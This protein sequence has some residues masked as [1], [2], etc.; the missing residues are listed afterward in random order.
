[1]LTCPASQRQP[2]CQGLL[3]EEWLLVPLLAQLVSVQLLF[4]RR[5][6]R[7][8][9]TYC[10]RNSRTHPHR[11]PK[12]HRRDKT[13]HPHPGI[14]ASLRS[15]RIRNPNG[16]ARMIPSL[17]RHSLPNRRGS[18]PPLLK[19]GQLRPKSRETWTLL[20]TQK[21]RRRHL[22]GLFVSLRCLACQGVPLPPRYGQADA[23]QAIPLCNH[24]G[25][26]HCLKL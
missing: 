23:K 15:Y 10:L 25:M 19:F 8:R 14:E 11:N 24:H 16:N 26:R 12:W 5:T 2:V 4:I 3:G 21:K 1:M 6:P 18:H 7:R 9:L 22:R 20:L 17:S 13:H